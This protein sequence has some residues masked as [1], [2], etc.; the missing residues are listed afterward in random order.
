[1]KEDKAKASY[2][3]EEDI[4]LARPIE[5]KYESSFQIDNFIFDLDKENKIIGLEMFNASK[6]FGIPKAFLKNIGSGKLEV[7][8]S[9]QYII[10]N[11][12]IKTKV[13]NSDR[14]NSLSIER[15]RPEFVNQAELHLA[16]A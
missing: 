5:R 4:F 8:I 14:V 12:Q 7:V 10:V 15:V 13:R 6:V 11:I 3:F 1:M 16:I 9:K 2:D